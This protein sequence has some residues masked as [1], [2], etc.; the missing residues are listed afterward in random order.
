MNILRD[1]LRETEQRNK[2]YRL[3]TLKQL[4]SVQER[5]DQQS[6][7]LGTTH[8]IERDND[9]ANPLLQD[10]FAMKLQEK[11]NAYFRAIDD[12]IRLIEDRIVDLAE[13][14]S[15]GNG[16]GEEQK[17]STEHDINRL[18]GKSAVYEKDIKKIYEQLEASRSDI[19]TLKLENISKFRIKDFS[20]RGFDSEINHQGSR[21]LDELLEM[22]TLCNNKHELL[23][24]KV[25]SNFN[26]YK[27][28]LDD[29]TD[30]DLSKNLRYYQERIDL[31]EKTCN[32]LKSEVQKLS[33]DNQKNDRND[34]GNTQKTTQAIKSASPRELVPSIDKNTVRNLIAQEAKNM[35]EF[36]QEFVNEH[37]I[38]CIT[39]IKSK[40]RTA[41]EKFDR[42]DWMMRNVEFFSDNMFDNFVKICHDLRNSKDLNAN[43]YK[44]DNNSDIM[45]NIKK[46]I[47]KNGN[48]E[49]NSH[50][51]AY[52]R[53]LE[54]GFFS[55]FNKQTGL[56]IKIHESIC[57]ILVTTPINSEISIQA[58][59]CINMI[60]SEEMMATK[61]M[62]KASFAKWISLSF[63]EAAN[64]TDIRFTSGLFILVDQILKDSS[65]TEA[66]VHSN[67]DIGIDLI[68]CL[69]GAN[70]DTNY[71]EIKLKVNY[72]LIKAIKSF[73]YWSNYL[74][75]IKPPE[76]IEKIIDIYERT[77]IDKIKIL[78]Q[79]VLQNFIKKVQFMRIL[80]KFN[81]ADQIQVN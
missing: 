1:S 19:E 46:L 29:F 49:S 2:E 25:V 74:D 44:V 27:K 78:S 75:L 17:L 18:K 14:R 53:V 4:R 16:N 60:A 8:L 31:V 35:L 15:K 36:F 42:I 67:S 77:K 57:S 63:K 38:N 30:L 54:I 70:D 34:R 71:M 56:D 73:S 64:Y 47:E 9:E 21:G 6:G 76:I 23:Q 55:K 79:L 5:V 68:N 33:Y 20:I 7:M 22:I 65:A 69:R 50:V 52:L 28:L 12:K 81:L 39:I 61:M 59:V 58:Q 80:Q 37:A 72:F 32:Y 45:S 41:T 24:N 40:L 11:Y 62:A 10:D 51:L 13:N 48:Y 26:E 66:L 3:D 43:M